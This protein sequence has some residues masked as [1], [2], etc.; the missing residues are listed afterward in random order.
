MDILICVSPALI[1]AVDISG[2]K[3]TP[4]VMSSISSATRFSAAYLTISTMFLSNKDSP[5]PQKRNSFILFNLID[6]F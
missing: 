4:F 2:V 6:C 3:N 5:V 1:S